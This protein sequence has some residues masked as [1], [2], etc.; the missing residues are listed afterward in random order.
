[1]FYFQLYEK[2]ESINNGPFSETSYFTETKKSLVTNY[3]IYLKNEL[4]PSERR[5]INNQIMS[6]IKA[7]GIIHENERWI[8]NSI[9]STWTDL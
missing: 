4:K 6:I 2:I 1:M 8:W 3:L 5:I 9:K 7:D